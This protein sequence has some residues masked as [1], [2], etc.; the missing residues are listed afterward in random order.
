[1]PENKK[2]VPDN[3]LV[4]IYNHCECTSNTLAIA[5]DCFS[6]E[7]FTLCRAFLVDLF[8]IFASRA[9]QLIQALSIQH[10]LIMV[11]VLCTVR[12]Y[13]LPCDENFV[14]KLYQGPGNI[15]YS[16]RSINAKKPVFF[17]CTFFFFFF[18]FFF[19]QKL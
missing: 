10:I 14:P 13:L 6:P 1:M 15:S 17:L 9:K 12:V 11:Y 16:S 19:S 3:L 8:N 7:D 5:K 4:T 18:F 2:L